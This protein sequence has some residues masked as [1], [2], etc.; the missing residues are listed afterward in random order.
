MVTRGGNRRRRGGNWPALTTVATRETARDGMSGHETLSEIERTIVDLREKE[1]ALQVELESRTTERSAMI[2]RRVAAYRDLAEVRMRHAVSDGVI[3]EA[4]RLSKRVANLLVARQKTINELK[5]RAAQTDEERDRLAR[6]RET[7]RARIAA[8]ETRLD[9]IAMRAR[10]ELASNPEYRAELE[11]LERAE[12]TREK[13]AT[14]AGQA[15][16]NRDEKGRAYENDPLFMYLWRRQYG[17]GAYRPSR[18]VRWL[19]G[20]VAE[21]VGYRE[22]SANYT[23]LNEIPARLSDHVDALAEIVAEKQAAVEKRETA[24]IKRLAGTDLPG[25]L[26][27]ARAREAGNERAFESLEAGR[28]DTL[29][30]L[31]QYAEGRDAAFVKAVE[32]SAGFLGHDRTAKLM[33]L[34]R[35]TTTPSD[36]EIAQRIEALGTKIE[37]ATRKIDEQTHELE[38][39]FDKREELVRIAADFRR[40]HFDDEASE[41]RGRDIGA[42]L[43]QELIRGAITGADYWARTRRRQNWRRR[44]ADGYR[45]SEN[46]PPFDDLFGGFGDKAEDWFEDAFEFDDDD[47]KS[48]GG[49]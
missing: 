44:P 47:F 7:L 17:R 16:I 20:K 37:N 29:A 27:E 9:E 3:D 42:V 36:D 15:A 41:F 23:V 34:A 11:E 5:A 45:R 33:Q 10:D 26:R 12:T 38:E 40:A 39:L 21:L 48:G 28:S 14:K 46:F 43:L 24:K 32:L 13:A 18:L 22:A 31:N 1:R 2:E 6:T 35:E 30:A 8:L 19:D 25:N 4:D 49:F